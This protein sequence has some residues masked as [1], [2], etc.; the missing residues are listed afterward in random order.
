MNRKVVLYI[1][2]SID[3]YIAKIDGDI[4]FL[5][6]AED[7]DEDYGY[8]SFIKDIDTVVWGRNTYAARGRIRPVSS[9]QG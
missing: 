3:G 9:V 8:Y 4:A 5:D 6:K 1:A 2:Q 7:G